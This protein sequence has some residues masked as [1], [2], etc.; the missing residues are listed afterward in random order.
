VDYGQATPV[1]LYFLNQNNENYKYYV[2]VT[3]MIKRTDNVAKA[4]VDELI[5]G[6]DPKKGLAAVLNN[7]AEVKN[8][9]ESEGLITV[10]FSEKLLGADKKASGEG[11][12]SVILSLTENT[13]VP[14]VQIT[15]NGDVKVSSTDQQSY[16]KPVSRP[17]HVNPTKM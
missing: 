13:G 14:K 12:Q 3:R 11:L 6:P 9:K 7:T 2:P 10:D 15:V 5:K 8:V 1:T 17:T 4:V 16:S